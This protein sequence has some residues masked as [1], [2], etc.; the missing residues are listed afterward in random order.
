MRKHAAAEIVTTLQEISET[1][2]ADW[3]ALARPT[4]RAT[5]FRFELYVEPGG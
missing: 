5:I 3:D 1:Q 4:A 2:R